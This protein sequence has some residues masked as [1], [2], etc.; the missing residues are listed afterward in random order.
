MN[1][2]WYETDTLYGNKLLTQKTQICRGCPPTKKSK[3][4]RNTH[5]PNATFQVHVP[6]HLPHPHSTGLALVP[7]WEWVTVWV[8]VGGLGEKRGRGTPSHLPTHT[9]KYQHIPTNN[10]TQNY[11]KNV[12]THQQHPYQTTCKSS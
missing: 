10:Q 6:V 7:L 8:Q 9:K 2:D 4:H 5:H 11:R 3:C 12:H 1:G